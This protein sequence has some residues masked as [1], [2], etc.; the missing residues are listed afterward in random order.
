MCGYT[1]AQPSWNRQLGDEMQVCHP[2]RKDLVRAAR[3]RAYLREMREAARG[4]VIPATRA[5]HEIH[6]ALLDFDR[7]EYIALRDWLREHG[8]ILW[9]AA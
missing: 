5:Q 6:A 9:E 3:Q 7:R 1:T 4:Q 8:H 2:R